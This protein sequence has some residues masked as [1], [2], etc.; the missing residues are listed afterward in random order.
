MNKRTGKALRL[1]GE[2]EKI[3]CVYLARQLSGPLSARPALLFTQPYCLYPPHTAPVPLF[4]MAK[5]T[6]QPVQASPYEMQTPPIQGVA[7]SHSYHY[8]RAPDAHQ[9]PHVGGEPWGRRSAP[10]ALQGSWAAPPFGQHQGREVHTRLPP[11]LP[12]SDPLRECRHPAPPAPL[13]TGHK[14]TAPKV[15]WKTFI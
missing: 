6:R 5:R 11:A 1:D 14:A 12:Q 13:G 15:Q 2:E 9:Q 8:P 7:S 4:N 10:S 3:H